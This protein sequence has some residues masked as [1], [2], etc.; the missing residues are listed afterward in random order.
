[1]EEYAEYEVEQETQIVPIGGLAKFVSDSRRLFD[2]VID[3]GTAKDAVKRLEAVKKLM[4]AADQYGA[5]AS[6]FCE[7]EALLFFRI[8]EIECSE[9]E[10]TAAKRRMVEWLRTKN[11]D[12]K[13]EILEQCRDGQRLHVLFNRETRQKVSYDPL[14]D[15]DRISQDIVKEAMR[16]GRTTLTKATFYQRAAHPERLDDS[17]IRAYVESTRDKLLRKNVL[18][19]GD[20]NG[21]YVSPDKCDRMEIAAI[22]KTRL[23]S[24]VADLKTIKQICAQTGFIVPRSGVKIICELIES[25]NDQT[26]VIELDA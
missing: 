10:L 24:I 6:Q 4:E 17:A 26:D 5:Y 8:A 2:S 21:T 12:E 23:E 22:V 11:D 3:S 13:A 1:M 9:N 20:G 25:L 15:C 16:T 18:G 14:K 19:L 7:Q